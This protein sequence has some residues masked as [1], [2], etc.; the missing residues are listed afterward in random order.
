MEK[1]QYIFKAKVNFYINIDF[2]IDFT[3]NMIAE[4][5]FNSTDNIKLKDKQKSPDYLDGHVYKIES[6]YIE[7]NL[8]GTHKNLPKLS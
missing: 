2:I 5:K 1:D 6:S 7:E 3:N 4:T 8:K